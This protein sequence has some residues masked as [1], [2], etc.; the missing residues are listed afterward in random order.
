MGLLKTITLSTLLATSLIAKVDFNTF[1]DICDLKQKC[2]NKS[3]EIMAVQ[4]L[5]KKRF[6]SSIEVTGKW[7][8]KTKTTIIAF[9]KSNSIPA[10]GYI[11]AKTKFALNQLLYGKVKKSTT[12]SKKA[13]K[14]KKLTTTKTTLKIEKKTL[15]QKSTEKETTKTQNKK[16]RVNLSSYT[17]FIRSVNLKKSFAI[18]KD[19][20]LLRIAK[21]A[22]THIKVDVSEQRIKLVVNGKVA[23]DAPCTTGAKRKLEPNT[24]TIRDKHTP[25]GTFRIME[26]I[27]VKRSTIFGDI[28][29]HGR[30]VYHGDR[31][32]YKGSW[33]GAKFVG[34]P[35]K[36]WMR[37][38]SSGIG[39]HASR[40]I[41]RYPASNGCIRL[42]HSV[43]N[44]LFASIKKGTKVKVVY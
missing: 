12:S 21:R 22:K 4:Y 31:R 24:R 35:L 26:K 15:A 43:A 17:A 13:Q 34:H 16:K 11:G 18:Y 32:K 33:K 5:L 25:Y 40:Y 39:L 36:K 2:Q 6:D 23:L 37:L 10:T 3:T 42:P 30:L 20:K 27:A 14:N 9:Q 41:K 1:G 28:Y 38:T 29:R 7:N 8:E 44:T 19:P